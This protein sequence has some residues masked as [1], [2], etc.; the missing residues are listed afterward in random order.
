[1]GSVKKNRWVII[2]DGSIIHPEPDT[3]EADPFLLDGILFFELYDYD[4]GVIAIKEAGKTK[5]VLER[6]YHLSFPCVFK[7]NGEYYMLPET[8]NNRQLE[9]YKAKNFPYDW[10]LIKVIKEGWYDD[11]V[12]HIDNGYHIFTTEGENN[13]RVFRSPTLLG[14]YEQVYS[15][16]SKQYRSAGKLY[17]SDG[18][19][20]RPCQDCEQG[21]G[22]GLIFYELDGYN[23]KEI[24]KFK[25]PEPFTGCHTYNE[26][27]IDARFPYETTL[28]SLK[29]AG[30]LRPDA[31]TP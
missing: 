16:N 29:D 25:P 15:D 14:D 27:I 13:L 24:S 2:S 30:D 28:D 17:K 23:H 22:A 9:L 12:M 1:M 10:E 8:V 20:I 4:K 5:V 31:S 26:G 11:P 21:Y 18:R 19:T 6:P 7:D 3:Y